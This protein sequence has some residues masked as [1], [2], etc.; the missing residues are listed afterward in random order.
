MELRVLSRFSE[1]Q[2]W[3]TKGI[4]KTDSEPEEIVLYAEN[5]RLLKRKSRVCTRIL[6][7]NTLILSLKVKAMLDARCVSAQAEGIQI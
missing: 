5:V 6:G 4:T 1:L 7:Q 3:L 2:Q